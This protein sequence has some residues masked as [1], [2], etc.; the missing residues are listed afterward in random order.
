MGVFTGVH[1]AKAGAPAIETVFRDVELVAD[2]GNGL[3]AFLGLLQSG[4][5]LLYG[6]L[7]FL[8]RVSYFLG[9]YL[10]C[11]WYGF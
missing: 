11:K 4:D 9:Q 6:K 5:D 1:A 8:R 7:A 3:L 10:S 2:F